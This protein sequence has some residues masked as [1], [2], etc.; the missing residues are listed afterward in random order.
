MADSESSDVLA[1]LPTGRPSR[2]SSRRGSLDGTTP[3]GGEAATE[4]KAST[5]TATPAAKKAPAAKAKPA[6]K[7]PSASKAT[8]AAKK[9][10]TAKAA[11]AAKKPTAAKTTTAARKPAA[12]KT[13]TAAKKPATTAAKKPT[14]AKTTTAAKKPAAAKATAA[15]KRTTS[16][17]TPEREPQSRRSRIATPTEGRRA[18]FGSGS[19]THRAR[20]VTTNRPWLPSSGFALPESKERP[21]LGMAI[22]GLA[23]AL[24]DVARLSIGIAQS[25]TVRRRGDE[26]EAADSETQEPTKS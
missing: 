2:R 7:K 5:A 9:P 19:P 17:S 26:I 16:A 24:G 10:T 15:T 13:T 20:K 22:E 6:A 21:Q 25:L 12:A 23:A 3:E 11:A 4:A 1:N 14:A 18:D 8:P